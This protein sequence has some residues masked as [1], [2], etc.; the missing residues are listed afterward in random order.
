MQIRNI[1]KLILITCPG[2]T[3]GWLLLLFSS[4]SLLAMGQNVRY[5]TIRYARTHYEKRI[6]IFKAEKVIKS[7]IIFLGNSLTQFGDWQKLLGDSTVINRGIAGDNTYGVLERLDDVNSR[8]PNK[9]FIEIGINDISQNIP[10]KIIVKN[11]RTIVK[12]IHE[13]SPATQIYITS[14]LPTNDNVKNEYPASFH[15]DDQIDFTNRILKRRAVSDNYIYLNL[16]RQV[17]DKDGALDTKY[18]QSDGLHLNQ[19]GY[20]VWAKMIS[21]VLVQ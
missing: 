16:N 11:I 18:A 15:K 9:L 7:N 17:R 8:K 4:V 19:L 2:A 10:S 1:T 5:D 13:N 21:D 14:V 3:K 6:A 12:Y 20:S